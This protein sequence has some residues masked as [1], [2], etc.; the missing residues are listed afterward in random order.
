MEP[1]IL[2]LMVMVLVFTMWKSFLKGKMT[3]I[4]SYIC[5]EYCKNSID[6]D[7]LKCYNSDRLI[8]H[9]NNKKA[10]TGLLTATL[11]FRE[12]LDGVK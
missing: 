7:G 4:R 5:A 12:S 10:L 9:I 11:F 6:I 2:S 8:L 3:K 1:G